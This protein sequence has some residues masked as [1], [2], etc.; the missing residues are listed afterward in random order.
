MTIGIR[1]HRPATP[2][3]LEATEF[4]AELGSEQ[5][6]GVVEETS[7]ANQTDKQHVETLEAKA[8]TAAALL[9]LSLSMR[10]FS[11]RVAMF[12]QLAD[13]AWRSRGDELRDEPMP[14]AFATVNGEPVRSIEALQQALKTCGDSPAT[15][16]LEQDHAYPSDSTVAGAPQVVMYGRLGS[17]DF[18]P[19]F[20]ELASKAK[21]GEIALSLRHSDCGKR[22]DARHHFSC[23]ALLYQPSLK[24]SP[25]ASC[26]RQ[27]FRRV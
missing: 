16:L 21:A 2:L 27:F 25:A 19:L 4:F 6:W 17:A 26:K 5:F 22:A 13:E 8:G 23:D 12:R 7:L 20:A 18:A 10:E 3:L 1:W 24:T 15:P 14:C 11:P 9:R